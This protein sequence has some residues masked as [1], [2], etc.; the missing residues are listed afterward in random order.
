MVDF[1]NKNI[2]MFYPYGTTRHYGESIKRELENRS[3]NVVGYDERPSQN[4]WSKI[5]IRLFKKKLPQYFNLY[6]KHIIS[7]NKQLDFSYILICRGEAFTPSSIELLR[8][9]FPNAQII[10]YLWD[11]LKTT[12]VRRIIPLCDKAYSFDPTDVQNNSF[13]QF[14]PTFFVKEYQAMDD[15]ITNCDID[16]LFIGTLHSNRAKKI[17]ELEK[18]FYTNGIRFYTY[19][20]IPSILVYFKDYIK[21][22]P[23]ISIKRIHFTPLSL[24][25]SIKLLSRS[26]AILDLNYPGQKSLS[27]RAFEAMASGRKYITT[28]EEIKNY[29]FYNSKNIYV[30]DINHPII[31]EEFLTTPF[32]KISDK[33]LYRYSIPGVIDDLFS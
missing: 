12:N 25:N 15:S 32:E 30:L 29:D 33:V 20:F 11:I 8:K 21:K 4:T 1:H 28:N 18:F 3:A 7:E 31:P 5:F 27:M 16:I 23:Y 24:Q 10:L 9:A 2:L 17:L 13:L 26:I 6:L 22:F 14:R 19:L